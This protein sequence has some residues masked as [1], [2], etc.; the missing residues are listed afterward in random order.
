MSNLS[1]G[2]LLGAGLSSSFN[3][4]ISSARSGLKGLKQAT[5][6]L[7]MRQNKLGN[8][9]GHSRLEYD[10]LGRSLQ[11]LKGNYEKLAGAIKKMDILKSQRSALRSEIMGT[12]AG[13]VAIGAPV[14]KTVGLA[15]NFQDVVKDISIT[16][17][18]SKAEEAG[19]GKTIRENALRFNQTQDDLAR[20]MGVLVAGGISSVKELSDFAPVLAKAA[21]ATRAN[22]EELGA[23]FISMRDNLKI[24]AKES[25][26]SLN[27]LAYAGKRGQFEIRDMAKWLPSL[28]PQMAALGLTGKEAVAEIGASLQIARKGAGTN[29]EAANNFKNFLAK[30]T[31]PDTIKDFAKAGIDLKGT[32]KTLTSQGFTPVQSMLKIITG[33]MGQKAPDA[34]ENLKKAMEIKDDVERQ[35]A[36]DRLKE[37]YKLGELFQDM[38]AMSFIKPALAN[39]GELG[40]IKSGAL[41]AG[42]KDLLGQDMARRLEGF[43]EQWKGLTGRAREL[44]LVIGSA[45]LPPLSQ[46][47][48][49]VSPMVSVVGQLAERFPRLTA[50]VVGL[51]GGLAAGKVAFFAF[52]Y[53]KTSILGFGAAL[54][55]VSALASSK[56]ILSGLSG[57]FSGS[58]IS[59]I[60]GATVA[61]RAFSVALLTSPIGWIGLAVGA[62]AFLIYK[63]WKPVSGF[64]RGLWRGLIEG[65]KPLEPAW[66]VFKKAGEL[67]APVLTPLKQMGGVLASLFKPV[68]DIG[69][70]AEAMGVRFGKAVAGILNAV[71]SLPGKMFDAGANIVKS[72][73]EGMKSMASKPI[74]AIK[75]IA[76]GIRAFLPFSPAKTGPLRD[77]HR[78]RLVETLAQS[79][80]PGPMVK[81]MGAVAAAALLAFPNASQLQ[82][83]QGGI[84]SAADGS[85]AMT[86]HYSPQIHIAGGQGQTGDS[87]RQQ[88]GEALRVSFDEFSRLMHRYERD[89]SRKG[90][91]G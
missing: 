53:L 35:A 84:R 48:G 30:V 13:A 79:I 83:A 82:H 54:Q 56:L 89:R 66:N 67:L 78:V 15:G 47:I 58:V 23:V 11:A 37:A 36:L 87:V 22:V 52:R 65:L 20:G 86:I 59:G 62:A 45:L 73:W 90:F 60:R 74:G 77:I 64:F 24:S 32:M 38:Q 85:R 63:Y 18:F 9:V 88:A 75:E 3:S 19:L 50:G 14:L 71:V 1:I 46:V 39:M 49:V 29:D 17:E 16:G 34:A 7:Q 4:V 10:R 12:V 6:D 81:A 76:G 41:D 27:M 51:A 26:S 70:K 2:I 21:T 72:L 68:E 61:V 40:S 44:G 42:T 57:S 69:G 8:I 31:A 43:N 28:A 91:A 25:E 80:K 5:Q 55:A 33:Y